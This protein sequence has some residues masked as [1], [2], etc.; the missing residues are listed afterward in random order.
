M[1]RVLNKNWDNFRLHILVFKWSVIRDEIWAQKVAKRA[2]YAIFRQALPFFVLAR[3]YC[4][5]GRLYMNRVRYMLSMICMLFA[6]G[7]DF[8]TQAVFTCTAGSAI[9][10]QVKQYAPTRKTSLRGEYKIGPEFL[11]AAT[12]KVWRDLHKTLFSQRQDKW[13]LFLQGDSMLTCDT[14][15]EVNSFIRHRVHMY[16]SILKLTRYSWLLVMLSRTVLWDCVGGQVL[17]HFPT[18]SLNRWWKKR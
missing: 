1:A 16:L 13:R 4:A 15:G 5:P 2:F 9:T 11:A 18:Q 10:I 6:Y 14:S 3:F 8:R 17:I 12:L 7:F